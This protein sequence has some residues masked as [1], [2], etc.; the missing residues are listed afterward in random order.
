[1]SV[2]FEVN[3]ESLIERF[4]DYTVMDDIKAITFII[5]IALRNMY[6]HFLGGITTETNFD[7]ILSFD[8][9]CFQI[10]I[11]FWFRLSIYPVHSKT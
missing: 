10:I 11:L 8:G 1:M 2:K 9:A 3:F 6:Y 5:I 4:V 7:L